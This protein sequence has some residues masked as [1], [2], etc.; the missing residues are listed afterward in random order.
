MATTI[1]AISRGITAKSWSSAVTVTRLSTRS[2][3]LAYRLRRDIQ[4]LVGIIPALV[5]FSK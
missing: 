1:V 4:L 5:S 2:A 3:V